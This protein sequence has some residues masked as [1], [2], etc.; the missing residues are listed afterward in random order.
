MK[1]YTLTNGRVVTCKQVSFPGMAGEITTVLD[2]TDEQGNSLKTRDVINML[3]AR[4]AQEVYSLSQQL[5]QINYQNAIAFI[6]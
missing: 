1:K 2:F 3:P 6:I 4:D 5:T